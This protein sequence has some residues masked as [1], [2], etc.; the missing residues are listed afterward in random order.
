M[1]SWPSIS[2]HPGG[3]RKAKSQGGDSCASLCS[4]HEALA[5]A[6]VPRHPSTVIDHVPK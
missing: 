4:A 3:L 1:I 5:F 6:S 2:C